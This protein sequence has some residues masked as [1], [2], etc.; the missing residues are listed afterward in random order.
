MRFFLGIDAG[1]TKTTAVLAGTNTVLARA[2]SGS[3]KVTRN[4]ADAAGKNLAALFADLEQQSGV[5]ATSITSACI[6]LSGITVPEI[7][8]WARAELRKHLQGSVHLCGDEEIAL[9]AA[10]HGG[11]GVL[12]IAGTGSNVVGRM[13]QGEIFHLGGWG[14]VLSDEGSGYWIGLQAARATLQALDRGE[15]TKL[16]DEILRLW[17]ISSHTEL[18]EMGNRV[19]GPDFSQLAPGVS[20]CAIQGDAVALRVLQEGGSLLGSMAVF[21]LRRLKHTGSLT[22]DNLPLALTGSV[23]AHVA[24]LREALIATVR[25]SLPEVTVHPEPVDAAL[26][27][28][29]RAQQAVSA[30]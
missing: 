1:G 20:T 15:P 2:H 29:W 9:D 21:A 16:F 3:I 10:F 30:H 28:V 7:A 22:G 24:P 27:A 26:G 5:A 19:P 23:A 8:E 14:P 25:G 6:G 11:P 17:T 12:V 18:V 13:P 4:G